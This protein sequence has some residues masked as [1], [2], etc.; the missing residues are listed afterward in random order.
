MHVFMPLI[1]HC[2]IIHGSQIVMRRCLQH[3]FVF[4]L[5][6]HLFQTEGGLAFFKGLAPSLFGIIPTR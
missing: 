1:L 3:F 2:D 4:V 6:R 5:H